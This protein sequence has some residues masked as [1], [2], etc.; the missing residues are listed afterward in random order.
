MSDTT[1]GGA[2]GA[3]TGAVSKARTGFA[4]SLANQDG[5]AIRLVFFAGIITILHKAG[6][7]NVGFSIPPY[8]VVFAVCLGVAALLY[9]MNATTYALRAFWGGRLVGTIGWSFVWMVAFVYSMNQWIGAASENEGAKSNQHKAAYVTFADTRDEMKSAK[10]EVTRLEQRLRMAPTRNADQA[11]AAIDNAKAH[12]FWKLTSECRETKG[13]QTR[14]FCSEYASAVADKA[15]ATEMLTVAEE[16]K[17]AKAR[18]AKAQTAAAGT[19]AET[20]EARNDLVIL[21]KYAG[22]NEDDART[23]NALGSIIAISIFLSL[24][25]A[26]RELEHLRAT[27]KR[28]PMF[29]LR[30]WYARLHKFLTGKDLE[31]SPHRS[32]SLSTRT[33]ADDLRS[34][35]LGRG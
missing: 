14:Q 9:E 5:W 12:K 29:P 22:M 21:T 16:M 11:Q 32:Y 33:L 1:N 2:I 24:A 3:L 20:S 8:A 30:H 35:G 4:A 18:L 28:V 34:A 25:T 7:Q 10:D 26:L 15:G 13:P 23:L 19:K 17:Q 27:Q 6:V 31:F